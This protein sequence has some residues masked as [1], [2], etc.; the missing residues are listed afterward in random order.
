M[1]QLFNLLKFNNGNKNKIPEEI[2]KKYTKEDI[3]GIEDLPFDFYSPETENPKINI[4]GWMKLILPFRQQIIKMVIDRTNF[5]FGPNTGS[6]DE[7]S[8]DTLVDS[9]ITV[10]RL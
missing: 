2:I 3:P 4:P 5:S 9:I 6:S 8:Y 10:I 1:K 7:N